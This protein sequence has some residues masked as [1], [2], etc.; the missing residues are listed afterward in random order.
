MKPDT[1]QTLIGVIGL[2]VVEVVALTRGFN[3]P[4]TVAYF[5]GVVGLVA[6]KALEDLPFQGGVG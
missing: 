4:V 3:G 2:T 6:P 1:R 5:V